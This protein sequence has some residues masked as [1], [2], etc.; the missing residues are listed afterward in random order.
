MTE[1]KVGMIGFGTVGSGVVKILQE[2][3]KLLEFFYYECRLF[4]NVRCV[5]FGDLADF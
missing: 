5:I 4:F 1:I 2:N 3:A